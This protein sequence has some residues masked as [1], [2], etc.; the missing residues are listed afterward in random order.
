MNEININVFPYE[1]KIIFPIYLSDQKFDALD[2]L[3]V[4]NN[5]L[6]IK[7]FNKTKCKNK[8]LF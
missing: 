5:Y 6:L 4:N 1:N 3:L 7:D 2:L 8:K